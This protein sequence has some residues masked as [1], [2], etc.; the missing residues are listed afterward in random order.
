MKKIGLFLNGLLMEE[1]VYTEEMFEFVA[2]D[3]LLAVRETGEMHE[4]K[5]YNDVSEVINRPS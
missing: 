1:Y 3:L 5:I 4:V 2:V